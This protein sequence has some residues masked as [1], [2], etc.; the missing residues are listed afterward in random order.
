VRVEE[1]EVNAFLPNKNHHNIHHINLNSMARVNSDSILSGISGKIGGMVFRQ[2]NGKTFVAIAPNKKQK[3]RSPMQQK[4]NSNFQQAVIYAQKAIADP[5][6][7]RMYKS[8]AGNGK[9][10]YNIALADFFHAPDIV[11]VDITGYSGKP[12]Q[13]IKIIVS[14]DFEVNAVKVTIH[15]QDGTLQE[16]GDAE[17]NENKIVWTYVARTKNK[18]RA[19]SKIT[20]IASDN[21]GNFTREEK[22]L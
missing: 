2:R 7:K 4:N 20:V 10:A 17:P 8:K 22:G 6:T 18:R 13:L 12:G 21:P 16:E 9:S 14:D 3:P 11:E 19:G 1:I 5:A 15:S